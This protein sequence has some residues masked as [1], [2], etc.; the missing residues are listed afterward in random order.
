MVSGAKA[1]VANFT[2]G[3]DYIGLV[4][5]SAGAYYY[6]P[7]TTFNT[8]DKNNKT[9]P[10]L[11]NSIACTGNTATASALSVGYKAMQDAYTGGLTAGRANI[12]VLMTD[13]RPNGVDANYLP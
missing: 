5:F 7:T 6:P 10:S 11:I 8:K 1:F 13:G 3:R 12:I 4:V 9:I 2:E